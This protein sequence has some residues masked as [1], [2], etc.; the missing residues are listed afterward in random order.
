MLHKITFRKP[1]AMPN[2]KH[3]FPKRKISHSE[4][5]INTATQCGSHEIPRANDF[6]WDMFL[7][8]CILFATTLTI[9]FV[10]MVFPLR[11]KRAFG[12]S[13]FQIWKL[14]GIM[15]SNTCWK[16]CAKMNFSANHRVKMKHCKAWTTFVCYKCVRQMKCVQSIFTNGIAKTLNHPLIV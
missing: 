14:Y 7:G 8:H 9:S 10:R 11:P 13:E 12:Q 2:H 1:L 6:N 3:S 15:V 5:T 16:I 4:R